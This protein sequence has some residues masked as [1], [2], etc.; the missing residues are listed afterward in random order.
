[1]FL[2]RETQAWL[3]LITAATALIQTLILALAPNVDPV[4]VGI[5]L[6][7]VGTF[8][9][10]LIAFIARTSTTPVADPQLKVGTQIRVTDASGTV[11][12]NDTVNKPI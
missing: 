7:A 11:I 10:V 8:L 4:Q 2:G 12:G 3:G 5:V 1:M 6:G 9:G